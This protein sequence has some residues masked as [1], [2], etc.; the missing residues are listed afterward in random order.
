MSWEAIAA[1]MLAGAFLCTRVFLRLFDAEYR[2]ALGTRRAV[3]RSRQRL[4]AK[5]RARLK[6]LIETGESQ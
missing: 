5:L 3:N 2:A 1:I 6:E 4:E